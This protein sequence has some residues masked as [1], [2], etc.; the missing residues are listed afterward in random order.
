[1]HLLTLMHGFLSG[2]DDCQ[3]TGTPPLEYKSTH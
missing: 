1:M 3:A 2:K